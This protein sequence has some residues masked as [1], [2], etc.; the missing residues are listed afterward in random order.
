MRDRDQHLADLE[1]LEAHDRD[2]QAYIDWTNARLDRWLVDWML[3]KG[4][5]KTAKV[6]ASE[7]RIEVCFP[8]LGSLDLVIECI[9]FITFQHFVDIDLFTDMRRIE[10]ALHSES[11]VEAL[12]WCSEN[13]TALRKIKV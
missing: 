12:T 13:K 8:L 2:E 5:E 1:A 7:N 11:C 9:L 10:K 3:R 4:M 6:L